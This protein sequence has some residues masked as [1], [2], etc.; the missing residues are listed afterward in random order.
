MQPSKKKSPKQKQNSWVR[1][2]FTTKAGLFTQWIQS[3]I[4]DNQGHK[5]S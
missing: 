4:M 3:K 5:K 1:K 2:H